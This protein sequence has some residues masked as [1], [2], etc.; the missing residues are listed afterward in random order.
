[1]LFDE[2]AAMILI[3]RSK[4]GCAKVSRH[5]LA[6]WNAVARKFSTGAPPSKILIRSS[7]SLAPFLITKPRRVWAAIALPSRLFG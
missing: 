2:A 4:T 3:N 1:L 6:L 7:D 5:I